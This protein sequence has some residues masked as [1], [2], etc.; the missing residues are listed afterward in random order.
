[1]QNFEEL[2]DATFQTAVAR[3]RA[4]NRLKTV[5]RQSAGIVEKS[6][7]INPDFQEAG[8]RAIDP[9]GTQV[10]RRGPCREYSQGMMPL[11]RADRNSPEIEMSQPK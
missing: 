5:L 3:A 11:R 2:A 1:M 7:I 10:S 6:A 9:T 4:A 8:S